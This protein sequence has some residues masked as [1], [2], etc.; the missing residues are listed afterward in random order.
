MRNRFNSLSALSATAFLVF[1]SNGA[2]AAPQILGLVAAAEPVPLTCKDG[3]CT[4]ELTTVCLQEY[5]DA[6][7][8]G[9]NYRASDKTKLTLIVSAGSG[10]NA[11][12]EITDQVSF[13]ALRNISSVA[14]S[15]P[16]AAVRKA[17]QGVAAIQ[18]GAMSAVIPAPVPGDKKPQTAYEIE[19]YTGPFRAIAGQVFDRNATAVASLGLLNQVINR[20]PD[21]AADPEDTAAFEG[22]WRRV[23]D[24]KRDQISRDALQRANKAADF[25]R[26]EIAHGML[27]SMKSC[28]ADQ[29]DAQASETTKKVWKALKPNG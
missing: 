5:R 20:M 10:A 9:T 15:V 13:K 3:T 7:M 21:A 11:T 8:P 27:P 14:I 18:V 1:A 26:A 22:V 28:I 17:G 25:C 24:E 12:L 29:H 16:E 23:V 19:T 6:P 2:V 4:A